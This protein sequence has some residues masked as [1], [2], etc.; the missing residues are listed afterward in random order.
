MIEIEL[1]RPDPGA[2]LA[3]IDRFLSSYPDSERASEVY[4][5]R[6]NL[7][8]DRG[9]FGGALQSYRRVHGGREAEALYSEAVCQ[10]RLGQTD[11][12]AET[13]RAYLHRFPSAGH[14]ADARRALGGR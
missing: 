5:L 14:A 3:D 8:R 2:A 6:G 11:A 4:W 9:D 12:A 7:L 13:L 10:E 1:G